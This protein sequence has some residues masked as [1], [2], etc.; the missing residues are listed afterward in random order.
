MATCSRA[1]DSKIIQEVP[2]NIPKILATCL[3]T[4]LLLTGVYAQNGNPGLQPC[5][6]TVIQF[7]G[8]QETD[9]SGINNQGTIVGSYTDVNFK[10]H[11]FIL[12]NNQF[13][14]VDFP[15][16]VSTGLVAINNRG[17]ILGTASVPSANAPQSFILENGK[18]TTL[19]FPG[20]PS[21]AITAFNDFDEFSGTD[22]SGPLQG[23]V[24][25]D[26]QR[27]NLPDF[28][29]SKFFPADLNDRGVVAGT[30]N[31]QTFAAL[32]RYGQFLALQA[33]GASNT[34][35][36]SVNN[37]NEVVGTVTNADSSQQAYFY[38]NGSFT[39][40]SFPGAF[41]TGALAVND[42]RQIVGVNFA[43]FQRQTWVTQ[44]CT[45]Q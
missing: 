39:L 38:S 42:H 36:S 6:F 41:F 4:M 44:L 43:G 34:S 33:P 25:S 15:T 35:A 24:I 18:F 45:R 1:A 17:Q 40:F 13:T 21:N 7:P 2:M 37:L 31:Q 5:G 10:V 8:A 23:F 22:E 9:A 30:V 20:T 32:L 12:S 27:I 14:S 3:I 28:N 29:G 11:G 16:A 19:N 26:G